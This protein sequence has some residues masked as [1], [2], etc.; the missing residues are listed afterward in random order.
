MSLMRLDRSSKRN[1]AKLYLNDHPNLKNY[2][3]S[4]LVGYSDSVYFNKLFKKMIGMTPKEYRER[5]YD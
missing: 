2:E 1:T 4:M 5:H 3:I